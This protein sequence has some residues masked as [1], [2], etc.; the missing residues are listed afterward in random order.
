M[1][2]LLSQQL[3]QLQQLNNHLQSQGVADSHQQNEGEYLQQLRQL[4]KLMDGHQQ[5]SNDIQNCLNAH[6]MDQTDLQ[7]T[8]KAAFQQRGKHAQQ[9]TDFSTN[10]DKLNEMVADTQTDM[11]RHDPVNPEQHRAPEDDQ[12]EDSESKC[13][14]SHS[15]LY[16]SQ[17]LLLL[18]QLI[19]Q[20]R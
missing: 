20:Q 18:Q 1:D 9:G 6:G 15:K 17:Q 12:A 16:N 2:P 11:E 14:S 7:K 10:N 19:E 8:L 13:A 3:S 5:Q 4:S